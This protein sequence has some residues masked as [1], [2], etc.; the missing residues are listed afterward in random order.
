MATFKE[1]KKLILNVWMPMV[2]WKK[3]LYEREKELW[4]VIKS[5]RLHY[6]V[7]GSRSTFVTDF[8]VSLYGSLT[9]LCLLDNSVTPV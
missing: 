1:P 6:A 2:Y 9:L 5:T 3:K 4:A 7:L 8:C